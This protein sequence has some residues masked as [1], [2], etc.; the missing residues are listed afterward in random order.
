MSH[1]HIPDGI[2][3][4]WLW[5]LG[6]LIVGFYLIFAVN[7]LKKH[8]LG[9]KI[10]MTGICSAFMIIAMSVEIV[11]ISYHVNLS[12]LS[13]IILGPVLAPLSIL[14]TSMFLSFMGHGGITVVGLN[15]IAIS[16]E[17]VIAFF[18]FKFLKN[19]LKKPV[20]ISAFLS[21]FVALI[22]S[23]GLSIGITYLGTGNSAFHHEHHEEHSSSLIKFEGAES[24][25]EHDEHE[26][27][28]NNESVHFNIKKFII[29]I[30]A[31]GSIGWTIE[32]ILTGFIINYIDKVKPD[33]LDLTEDK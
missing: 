26:E 21:T 8:D 16:T 13:G 27:S 31:F 29:L 28:E 30:L 32:S 17:A 5:L 10:I 18:V 24:H 25:S 9:K 12:A 7:Y 19:T 14:V 1:I 33:I 22:I 6:F 11:P 4:I 23:T 15:T 3:P 2:L 20:I